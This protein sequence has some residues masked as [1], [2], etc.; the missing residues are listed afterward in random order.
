[1]RSSVLSPGCYLYDYGRKSLRRKKQI[2]PYEISVAEKFQ[3]KLNKISESFTWL[4]SFEADT[5]SGRQACILL[6]MRI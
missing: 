1:M 6:K 5:L 2:H 3:S 4:L